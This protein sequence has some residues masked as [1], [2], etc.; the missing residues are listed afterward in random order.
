MKR[1]LILT[2]AIILLLCAL[3][4]CTAKENSADAQPSDTSIEETSPSSTNEGKILLS[5]ENRYR[6]VYPENNRDLKNLASKI[7]D[8]L[9]KLD[10]IAPTKPAYY[11]LGSDKAADDGSPEILVGLT[12]RAASEAAAASLTKY[13]DFAIHIS[14]K[15]IAIYANTPERLEAAIN[16]FIR[17]MSASDDGSVYY[18][19]T[20]SYVDVYKGDYPK[21]AIADT[22]LKDYKIVISAAANEAQKAASEELAFILTRICG[23]TVSIV[24]D[25]EPASEHEILLCPVDRPESKTSSDDNDR[26][27]TENGKIVIAPTE[28]GYSRLVNMLCYTI[29]QNRGIVSNSDLQ[30]TS[31]S[32]DAIRSV[33][34]GAVNISEQENGLRFNK[35]SDK[36]ITEWIKY[37]KYNEASSSTGIKLD[38][39]TNSTTFYFKASQSTKF[40]LFINGESKEISSTGIF[41][42]KLEG[43]KNRITVLFPNHQVNSTLSEVRL[44]EGATLT[45]YEYSR[46]FLIV[47]DSITQ[48][49][50][51]ATDSLSWANRITRMFDADSVI[52]AISGGCHQPTTIDPEVD[53]I[54]DYI[55]V[56]YGTNDWS[57]GRASLEDFKASAQS[58]YKKLAEVY[59]DA[60]I[61]GITPIW[62]KDNSPS[63]VGEFDD[64]CAELKAIIESVGG[65]AVNG[66]DLVPHER[67]YYGDDICLH[68]NNEGF[69]FYANNLYEAVK[70]I[71]K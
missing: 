22:P 58:Y 17:N 13:H 47:G 55:F 28:N 51:A 8:K 60:K 30:F 10:P 2:L 34:F 42:V 39:Y 52:Q 69:E 63:R 44:D 33:A 1:I 4:S 54:P 11:N 49:Y 38:F 45:P 19:K 43:E 31:L 56:A 3:C 48:G 62:R 36:Q 27:F 61:I 24:T 20:A 25:T 16:Y 66:V 40:E 50:S 35:F 67:Q 23:T 29:D 65:Y 71:I 15:K 32:Y 7:Y 70:D 46:K 37:N 5:G 14:D 59:P 12:T 21:A 68:P 57:W 18:D 6:I 41:D 64:M 26:L 9:L 53:F